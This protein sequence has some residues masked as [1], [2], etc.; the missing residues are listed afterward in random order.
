MAGESS[1]IS[2]TGREDLQ[3]SDGDGDRLDDPGRVSPEI[4][5]Q[6]AVLGA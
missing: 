1:P 6:L 3:R 2:W 5:A 4:D